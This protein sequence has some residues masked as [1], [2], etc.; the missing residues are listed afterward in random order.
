MVH[1]MSGE[2]ITSFRERVDAY[3]GGDNLQELTSKI[4]DHFEGAYSA[5]CSLYPLFYANIVSPDYRVVKEKVLYEKL[6]NN[7]EGS[8]EKFISQ[9]YRDEYLVYYD[10]PQ[11]GFN[12]R[13]H[14]SDHK[15]SKYWNSVYQAK[16]F[17]AK[18]SRSEA[19]KV[20]ALLRSGLRT[21]VIDIFN[22]TFL[23]SIINTYKVMDD[24]ERKRLFCDIFSG[25]FN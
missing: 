6:F 9:K 2:P 17:G 4:H 13:L 24:I 11:V 8:F 16:D 23:D 19:V 5:F 1:L 14:N 7:N 25:Y 21:G 12:E 15:L 22:P 18:S 10:Y 20:S 3:Y